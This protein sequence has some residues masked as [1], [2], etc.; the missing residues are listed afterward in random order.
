MPAAVRTGL[1]V[2]V[3]AVPRSLRDART[4]LVTSPSAVTTFYRHA[5]DVIVE[6]SDLSVVALFGPEHGLRGAAQAGEHVTSSTDARTGLP[7]HSLYG[8]TRTP[9]AEMLA[10]IDVL[11]VD[12]QDIPVR[13]A[14]FASTAFNLVDAADA[15]GIEVVILDRPNALTGA[16]VQGN[17]LDPAFRS[18]VGGHTVPIRHGLTLGELAR[19]YAREHGRR[20]PQ[21]VAMEGWRRSMWFDETGLPWVLP[22]PN[23]PTLDTLT[24]YPATCLV[25]GTNLSEGRGTTKPFEM[26]GAPW[27]DGDTLATHLGQ[28]GLEGV[29][30]RPCSFVP[31]FS[32]H[33][34]EVCNGVQVHVTDRAALDTPALGVHLLA[35]LQALAP[36]RFAW[37]QPNDDSR[38]FFIDLL[39][40]TDRLRRALDDGT[41]PTSIVD[42]WHAEAASFQPR[43]ESV[44]LYD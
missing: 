4:G 35:Q 2:I 36:E 1:D 21:V 39:A 18:F 24:L 20:E 9:T 22:S 7:V 25:E 5:I 33:A 27:V 19:L 6:V 11:L 8:A 34:G 26:I 40:G 17:V 16:A 29:A 10:G 3:S 13:Y 42:T 23:M 15:H 32:K 44:A 37:V 14:T 28:L 31:S 43:H 30:F 41:K 38:P 12:K